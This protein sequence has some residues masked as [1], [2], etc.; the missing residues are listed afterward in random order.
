MLSEH[1]WEIGVSAGSYYPSLTQEF[2]GNDL[3]LSYEDDHM[4]MQFFAYSYHIDELDDPEDVACRL[5][6]LQILLNGALRLSWNDNSFIPVEFTYFFKCNGESRHNVHASNI[7]RNPFSSDENIDL[8]EHPVFPAKGRLHSR[9]L[10]ICKKDE[11]L[12]SLV[13]LV[14]LISTNNSLEKIMTWGTLYKIHD[15][16]KFH[17]KSNGYD[18]SKLGDSKRID[19]FKAACNNSPLLGPFARHGDMGWTEPKSAITDIDEAIDLIIG[20]AHNFCM[21]HLKSKHSRKESSA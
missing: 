16:V 6:S 3:G 20:Y 5:F 9:I 8:L 10:N 14:G 11:A 13:F 17:S 1:K 7:E 21:E 12:R 15:S 4:G 19:E 18:E 2:W